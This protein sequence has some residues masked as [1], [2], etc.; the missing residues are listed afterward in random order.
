MKS[1]KLAVAVAL[2]VGTTSAVA[3]TV[4]VAEDDDLAAKVEEARSLAIAGDA[5]VVI[6]V[7]PGTYTLNGE[8]V[9]DYGMRLK[10][11]GAREKTIITQGAENQRVMVVTNGIIDTVTIRGGNFKK[12]WIDP[13]PTKIDNHAGYTMVL[14]KFGQDNTLMTNCVVIG[15]SSSNGT[16]LGS[17]GGG[18]AVYDATVR[19]SLLMG[20][21]AKY[22]NSGVLY[23]S[24][25]FI[26]DTEITGGHATKAGGGV[27]MNIGGKMVNCLIHGD[28]CDGSG[29]G[30]QGQQ[31][32][33]RQHGFYLGHLGKTVGRQVAGQYLYLLVG[34]GIA[35][36]NLHQETVQLGLGQLVGTLLLY[37]VLRGDDGKHGA[38]RV[39][40]AVD[41]NLALLHHLEQRGLGLGRRTV[42]LIGQ[43]HV[44]EYRPGVEVKV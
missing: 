34:S 15:A 2:V 7:A 20:G 5:E 38:H 4:S 19:D 12:N 21:G 33:L 8:I 24:S 28:V 37:R 36:R 30:A 18:L 11:T 42:Y 40:N 41:G 17:P 31:V 29:G 1:L 23:L 3:A 10:G 27:W 16:T 14:K 13:N 39:G 44:G 6:A 26:F 32:G 43:H 9:I 35:H 22:D 25:G